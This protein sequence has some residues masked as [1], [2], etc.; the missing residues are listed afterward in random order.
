MNIVTAQLLQAM[1]EVVVLVM[2]SIAWMVTY[3]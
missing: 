3:D 1:G 2:R